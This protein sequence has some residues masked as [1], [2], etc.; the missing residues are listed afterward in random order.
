MVKIVFFVMNLS[1]VALTRGAGAKGE[2][3]GHVAAAQPVRVGQKGAA[4][5]LWCIWA[6]QLQV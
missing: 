1:R 5:G 2:R 4:G 6:I 3:E